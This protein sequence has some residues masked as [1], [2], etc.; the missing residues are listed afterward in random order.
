MD[1]CPDLQGCKETLKEICY[2]GGYRN[3]KHYL[4]NRIPEQ[5]Q[6]EERRG[7]LTERVKKQLGIEGNLQI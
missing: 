5:P 6:T 4:Q 1:Y 7:T 3:C 2:N